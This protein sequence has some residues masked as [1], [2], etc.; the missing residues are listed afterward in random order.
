VQ[1]VTNYAITNTTPYKVAFDI[2]NKKED[3]FTNTNRSEQ[4]FIEPGAT[5]NLSLEALKVYWI[6][7]YSG[8]Y[9]VNNWVD[10]LVPST[11][12][13]PMPKLQAAIEDDHFSIHT[14]FQDT[15]RSVLLNGSEL[16]STWKV[17]ISSPIDLSGTH[18]FTFRRDFQCLYTYTNQSGNSTSRQYFYHIDNLQWSTLTFRA[19]LM[20]KQDR[21][22][23]ALA[24]DLTRFQQGRDTLI[25][26]FYDENNSEI[27]DQYVAVRQ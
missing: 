3:Y 18:T 2:Y 8:D 25:A 22:F 7:W 4:Y 24:F 1:T 21:V 17:N 19:F 27:G 12:A 6:D 23:V 15:S 9:T 11:D 26:T 20:A 16:S 5:L 13:M 14:S 10:S